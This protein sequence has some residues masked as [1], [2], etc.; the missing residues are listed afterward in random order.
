MDIN[1]IIYRLNQTTMEKFH[2][3][4]NLKRLREAKDIKQDAL[5]TDLDLSQST[6]SRMEAKAKIPNHNL[7]E[8]TAVVLDVPIEKLL[9]QE[10]ELDT[11]TMI[12][13]SGF[14]RDPEKPGRLYN[15]VGFLIKFLL[16]ISV[17]DQARDIARGV[18]A[19]YDNSE[20]SVAGWTAALITFILF[21]YWFNKLEKLLKEYLKNRQEIIRKPAPEMADE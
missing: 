14:G 16:A 4:K 15:I 12:A 10:E 2:Y 19:G 5:G 11:P 18:G 6:V 21:Y 13:T 9:L 17:A 20:S 8:K 7:V 3:G 1:K